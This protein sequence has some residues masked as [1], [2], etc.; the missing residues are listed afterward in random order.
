MNHE[1]IGVEEDFFVLGGTPAQAE[2]VAE[3]IRQLFLLDLPTE[4]LFQPPTIAGQAHL[5]EQ[6]RQANKRPGQA[7]QRAARSANMPLSF[8][9]QRL[10]FLDQLNPNSALYNNCLS[11][12]G[13]GPL[14]EKLF[15]RSLNEVVRRHEAL[16]TI[17]VYEQG[18]PYQHILPSLTLK[19]PSVDLQAMLSAERQA[20]VERL[21]AEEG[22]QPFDLSTGP[23]IRAKLLRLEPN[24]FMILLSIHHIVSDGWSMGVLVNE[25]SSLYTAYQEQRPAPLEDIPIQYVDFSFWQRERL[26]GAFLADNLSYWRGKLQNLPPALNLLTDYP[27]PGTFTFAGAADN[28]VLP[29]QL[30]NA[31]KVF[32]QQQGVSMFMTLLSA[33]ALLLHAYSG[34]ESFCIGTPIAGRSRVE[35]EKLI[36]LFINMLVLRADVAGEASYLRFLQQIKATTLEAFSHQDIPFELLVEKLRVKR[37]PNHNPFFQVI[38]VLANFKTPPLELA[39]LNTQLAEIDTGTAKFDLSLYVLEHTEGGLLCK[40]EY[41]TDLFSAETIMRMGQAY[42]TI[43]EKIVANPNQSIKHLLNTNPAEFENQ[44]TMN[45]GNAAIEPAEFPGDREDLLI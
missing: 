22:F 37:D 21:M 40:L 20:A 33:Y 3:E 24:Q 16:R 38:F 25:L 12:T 34:D 1:Q 31:L 7:I 36:G 35:L 14:D 15:E 9:Q 28:F 18:R 26:Q 43:L 2:A 44:H 30:V 32:S 13:A 4:R 17:F 27:R 6:I 5:I 29:V 19:V 11:V 23:L 10:W 42:V 41:S 45:A 39:G 8:A